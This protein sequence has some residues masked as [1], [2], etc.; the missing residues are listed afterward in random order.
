[1]FDFWL[2]LVLPLIA[3]PPFI[4]PSRFHIQARIFVDFLACS[5][6]CIS[7][8]RWANHN[9]NTFRCWTLGNLVTFGTQ[10]GCN[11][12]CIGFIGCQSHLYHPLF[13]AIFQQITC[14]FSLSFFSS[15]SFFLR[16]CFMLSLFFFL[17]F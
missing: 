10:L 1:P 16:F 6:C 2:Q 12:V 4:P 13:V 3:W 11:G 14:F 15:F 7:V 8:F 5:I 17:C 9:S